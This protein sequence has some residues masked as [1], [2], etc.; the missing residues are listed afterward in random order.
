MGRAAARL[1]AN[2][3]AGFGPG[4]VNVPRGGLLARGALAGAF[5][6]PLEGAL[7]L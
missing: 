3:D 7:A 4:F 6:G 5:A 1:G 2:F